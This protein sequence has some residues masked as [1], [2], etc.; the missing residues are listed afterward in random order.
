MHSTHVHV[1]YEFGYPCPFIN[2]TTTSPTSDDNW[3]RVGFVFLLYKKG[4]AVSFTE[5]RRSTGIPA[6]AFKNG[7]QDL[8][9]KTTSPTSDDNWGRVGFVF[10]LSHI[11][12]NRWVKL[13]WYLLGIALVHIGIAL[14]LHWYRLSIASGIGTREGRSVPRGRD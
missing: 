5:T 14:V 3:G 13:P 8:M 9:G 7:P 11:H 12:A 2:R 10:L 6:P 1:W 4:Y